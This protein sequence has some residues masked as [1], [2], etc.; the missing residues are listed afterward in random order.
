MHTIIHMLGQNLEKLILIRANWAKYQKIITNNK[1][2][3]T[4][5]NSSNRRKALTTYIILI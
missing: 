4:V 1:I 5:R 2:E 3:G